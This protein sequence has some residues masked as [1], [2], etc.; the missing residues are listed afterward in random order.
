MRRVRFRRFPRLVP[1]HEFVLFPQT[2]FAIIDRRDFFK[3]TFDPEQTE[4][5]SLILRIPENPLK[6]K[7]MAGIQK[8]Q[9]TY[10][11]PA[12]RKFLDLFDKCNL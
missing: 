7:G 6:N 8:A 12:K 11:A 1:R 4:N 10:S 9:K 3:K 5:N 2:E